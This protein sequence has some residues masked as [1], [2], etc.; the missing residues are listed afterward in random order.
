MVYFL[1]EDKWNK[2]RK[3]KGSYFSYHPQLHFLASLPGYKGYHQIS[4]YFSNLVFPFYVRIN[5]YIE[6][7]YAYDSIEFYVDSITEHGILQL[8]FF[9]LNIRHRC[10]PVL[11]YTDLVISFYLLYNPSQEYLTISLSIH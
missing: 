2:S 7:V 5:K 6:Y 9:S 3:K 10:R 11:I 1:K 8:T 4:V